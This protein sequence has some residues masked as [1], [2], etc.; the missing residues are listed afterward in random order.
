[1]AASIK[2]IISKIIVEQ[3]VEIIEETETFKKDTKGAFQQMA[4]LKKR[5]MKSAKSKQIQS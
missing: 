4:V 1:M 5:T 3:N 2:N